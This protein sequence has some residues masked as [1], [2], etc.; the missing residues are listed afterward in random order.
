MTVW[1]SR[2][3]AGTGGGEGSGMGGGRYIPGVPR[4]STPLTGTPRR[5]ERRC[6]LRGSQERPHVPHARLTEPLRRVA[7]FERAHDP[8]SAPLLGARHE[9]TRQPLDVVELQ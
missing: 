2:S 8:P 7:A 6:A 5:C 4:C 1:T 3:T 9:L